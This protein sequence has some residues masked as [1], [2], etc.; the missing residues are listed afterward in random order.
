MIP[1]AFTCGDFPERWDRLCCCTIA[2]ETFEFLVVV[3][4]VNLCLSF[5]M[6]IFT[7]PQPQGSH[8]GQS[9]KLVSVAHAAC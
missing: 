1:A 4:A 8:A 3:I 2:Q 5:N 9:L 6:H 7:L